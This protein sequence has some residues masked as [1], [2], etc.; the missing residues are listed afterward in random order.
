MIDAAPPEH[1][2]ALTY[3]RQMTEWPLTAAALVFLIAY[4][5]Q[6]LGEPTGAPRAVAEWTMNLTWAVFVVDYIISLSLSRPRWRWFYTH[7]FDLAVV[8]LPVLRPLRLLRLVTLLRVLQ[9]TAGTALRGKIITYVI[10][11]VCLLVFVG[12]LAILEAERG[13]PR[14][15]IESYGDALWWAIVTITTVGYGDE[16]TVTITG[17]LVAV[18]LMIGGITL[19]STATGTLASWIVERIRQ[20]DEASQA[21]TQAQFQELER[22]LDILI[23][24]QQTAGDAAGNDGAQTRSPDAAS[25]VAVHADAASH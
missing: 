19:I 3:W 24:A 12:S 5:W 17:R 16:T 22:K 14:S 6:V 10:G 15:Q 2:S 25:T 23:A 11:A 7:L 4:A 1:R 20:D 18:A 9:R 8:A 13:Q 21:A